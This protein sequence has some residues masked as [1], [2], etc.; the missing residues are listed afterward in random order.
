MRKF[1]KWA[2]KYPLLYGGLFVLVYFSWFML[3]EKRTGP[4]LLVHSR[5]DDMI[6]FIKYMIIPYE[7][8]FFY[9]A[10]TIMYFYFS[11]RED[12]WNACR[13]LFPAMIIALIIYTIVPTG[14]NLRPQITDTDIFS[15]L[16]VHL[17]QTDT[18]TNVCPSLHVY[19]SVA[20][21]TVIQ[22]SNAFRHKRT[23]KTCSWILCVLICISTVCLKQH[24]IIDVFWA[25]VLAVV[26]Y[27]LSYKPV[28]F[29][30][31]EDAQTKQAEHGA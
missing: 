24:S 23:V 21:N 9:I 17:Y 6:P 19:N 7:L 28:F 12:F 16:I 1:A 3:L 11:S 26:L 25:L 10:G 4:F 31:G 13:Y 14:L 20:L 27:P 22:R 5:L 30:S 15:R 2:I 29:K 18:P 8:W